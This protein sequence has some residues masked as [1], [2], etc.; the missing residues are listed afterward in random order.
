M[1]CVAKTLG[2]AYL[3]LLLW[4]SF[5]L[6]QSEDIWGFGCLFQNTGKKS[7]ILVG[8]SSSRGHK[9]RNVPVGSPREVSN[10][11]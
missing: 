1:V 2:T 10:S 8:K 3:N 9:P 5:F 11:S 6:E 4:G 7:E